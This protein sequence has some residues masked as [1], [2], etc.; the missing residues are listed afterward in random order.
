MVDLWGGYHTYIYM[1]VY[2]YILIYC[3]LYIKYMDMSQNRATP[4]FH[5]MLCSSPFTA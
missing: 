1:Y 2:N 5:P 4:Q 3:I